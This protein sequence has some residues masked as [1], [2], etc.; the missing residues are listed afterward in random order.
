MSVFLCSYVEASFHRC[1]KFL[2]VDYFIYYACAVLSFDLSA[3]IVFL[4]KTKNS[5]PWI[6]NSFI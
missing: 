2:G 5:K 1:R 4:K 6:F 3:F